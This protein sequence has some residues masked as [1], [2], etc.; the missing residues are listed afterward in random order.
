MF[1]P[2]SLMR[3]LVSLKVQEFSVLGHGSPHID[4]Q[5]GLWV[6]NIPLEHV[7]F[8]DT[9]AHEHLR[10][11]HFLSYKSKDHISESDILKIGQNSELITSF[12]FPSQLT[13]VFI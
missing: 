9:S 13:S 6:D 2:N 3:W 10:R 7:M 4:E 5:P 1:Y 11:N 12:G 8:S